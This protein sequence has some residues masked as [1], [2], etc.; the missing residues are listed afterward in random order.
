LAA[1]PWATLQPGDEVQ[2]A[3]RSQPYKVKVLLSQSGTATDPIRLTGV[4]GPNGERPWLDGVGATTPTGTSYPFAG[5]QDRGLVTITRRTDQP[6]GYK[7]SYLTISGLK[8]SGAS[9]PSTFTDVGGASRAY[10]LNAACVFI[11]RGEHITVDGSEVTNC[12]NGIFG[13]SGDE[14]ATLSRDLRLTNNLIHGNG[15]VERDREHNTYLEAIGC[16]YEGN[17]YGDL[18][19]G[20]L[21]SGLKDRCAGTVIRG[22]T[23]AG[24]AIFLDLVDAEESWMLTTV[25]PSY[26]TTIVEQN[27]FENVF[28]PGPAMDDGGFLVHY[29]GDTGL[30][31]HYRKGTLTFRN[32]SVNIRVN[33]SNRYRLIL[34]KAET[35]DELINFEGNTVTVQPFTAG[36]AKTQLCLMEAKGTLTVVGNANRVTAGW[37]PFRDGVPITGQIVNVGNI[38]S[39]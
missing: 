34:I 6:W 39:Q 17:V 15:N 13:A 14:E 2:I 29:G 36:Q 38:V 31:S 37:T 9:S 21:G 5:T 20:A 24:G 10:T 28:D 12:G 30:P 32:N 4:P 11:E 27:V 16:T 1:V 25:D 7:P 35:D 3:Y 18:K 23:I 19:L 22:N 8:L 33:Q 26:H